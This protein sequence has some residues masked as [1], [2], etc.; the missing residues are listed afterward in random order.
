MC[1]FLILNTNSEYLLCTVYRLSLKRTIMMNNQD[2]GD[3]SIEPG[4]LVVKY[5]WHVC[6]KTASNVYGACCWQ[7]RKEAISK[8]VLS[9][10]ACK[11]AVTEQV[12][13]FLMLWSY[14][15]TLVYALSSKQVLPM[16]PR[17]H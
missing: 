1:L 9:L 7:S 6:D 14:L 2:I 5:Y 3:E 10:L 15:R 8:I 12:D 16:I 13:M 4:W 11:N 17:V